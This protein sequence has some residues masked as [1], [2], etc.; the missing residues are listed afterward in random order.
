MNSQAH[1]NEAERLQDSVNKQMGLIHARIN[2]GGGTT[3]KEFHQ[4]AKLVEI[5]IGLAQ[6]HATLATIND[7]SM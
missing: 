6:S 7:G 3:D 2:I 1:K 4:L 5:T